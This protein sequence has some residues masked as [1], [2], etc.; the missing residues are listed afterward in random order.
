MPPAVESPQR[1]ALQH[2]VDQRQYIATLQQRLFGAQ[3]RL[4][5][6]PIVT[7]GQHTRAIADVVIEL[8]AIRE[9]LYTIGTPP[10]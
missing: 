3:R 8:E 7:L 10:A 5:D 6:I 9:A 1:R 2:L 4:E